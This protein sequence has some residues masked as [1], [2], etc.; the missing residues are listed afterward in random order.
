MR[1]RFTALFSAVALPALT[2]M[3]A[4]AALT[5]TV[6]NM[7]DGAPIP[8]RH[9]LCKATTDGKST[10]GENIRPDIGWSGAPIGTKSYAIIVKDPDVPADFTDAGKE[11]KTVAAQAKRQLFYHWAVTDIPATVSSIA[12]GDAK[13][14][15]AVGIQHLNSLGDYVPTPAQY[16]GPCPPWNDA[17]VHRYH[18]TV[19][20]LDVASLKLDKTTP[21]SDVEKAIATHVLARGTITGTY[22]L[23]PALMPKAH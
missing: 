20:A 10:G 14:P 3:A 4:P 17:R 9:A 23:N 21:A 13:T 15:P 8:A 2:A 11:G 12:G 5:V 6:E 16:G 7:T 19:M 1:F 18:F 22:T